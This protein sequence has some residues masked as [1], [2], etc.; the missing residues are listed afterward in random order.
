M[1]I[2]KTNGPPKKILSFNTL[3]VDNELNL[4]PSHVEDVV[5]I[6]NTP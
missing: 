2:T 4:T 5:E 1:K 3:D 6:F